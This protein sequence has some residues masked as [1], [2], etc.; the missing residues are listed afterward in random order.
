MN[1]IKV[2]QL[3]EFVDYMSGAGFAICPVVKGVVLSIVP[4]NELKNSK[5]IVR[6]VEI[7]TFGGDI[8][9]EWTDNLKAI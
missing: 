7:L 6:E 4:T 5:N 8:T 3:V 1:Q 2:G 9:H